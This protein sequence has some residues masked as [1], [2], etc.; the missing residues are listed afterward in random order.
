VE[1]PV[2]AGP[3]AQVGGVETEAGKAVAEL[4]DRGGVRAPVVVQDDDRLLARV[5]EVVQALEGHP[6]REGAVADHRD[7]PPA[8][9]ELV[10][11]G[12]REPMGVADHRGGVA[13]LDPVVI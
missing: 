6:A 2:E 5:A 9:P 10:L 1:H 4:R 3:V 11:L 7:D 12:D 8:R 13:V